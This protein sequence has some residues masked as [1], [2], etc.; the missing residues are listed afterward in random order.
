MVKLVIG[1]VDGFKISATKKKV[2]R[3]RNFR[4]LAGHPDDPRQNQIIYMPV[5]FSWPPSSYSYQHPHCFLARSVHQSPGGKTQIFWGN[6]EIKFKL[7]NQMK[8]SSLCF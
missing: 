7:L 8:S 1:Q 2:S 4:R 6:G 5:W 3:I